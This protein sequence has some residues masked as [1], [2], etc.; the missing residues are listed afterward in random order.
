VFIARLNDGGPECTGGNPP[1]HRS[2]TIDARAW[3]ALA[4]V[5]VF[6]LLYGRMIVE[7]KAG[8]IGAAAS[9]RISTP[10]SIAQGEGGR[11]NHFPLR[12]H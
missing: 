9:R 2:R 12:T 8:P 4:W 7:R 10:S 5:I 1:M 11:L 3:F 6:G